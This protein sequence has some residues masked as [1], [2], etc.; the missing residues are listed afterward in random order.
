MRAGPGSEFGDDLS[1]SVC[2]LSWLIVLKGD[3]AR[4]NIKKEN[5]NQNQTKQICKKYIVCSSEDLDVFDCWPIDINS[6]CG[7]EENSKP[8]LALHFEFVLS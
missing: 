1:E 5:Q 7:L 3:V 6:N 2:F 8:A 4:P